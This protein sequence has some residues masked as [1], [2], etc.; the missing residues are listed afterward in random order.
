MLVDNSLLLFTGCQVC[1]PDEQR[2]FIGFVE[3]LPQLILPLLDEDGMLMRC[4][5]AACPTRDCLYTDCTKEGRLLKVWNRAGDCF[6]VAAFNVSDGEITDTLDF[7]T[8]PGI[9]EECEYIAYEYFSKTY[10]R[11]NAYED[12]EVGLPRDGVAV[13]SLYPITVDE[14]GE[15]FVSVGAEDKYVPIASRNKRCVKVSALF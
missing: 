9:S 15:E 13:W 3:I 12:T 6:A 7:G 4:E 2:N 14:N 10:T 8:I 1:I 5:G 11:V